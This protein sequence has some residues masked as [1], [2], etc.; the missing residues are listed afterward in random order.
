MIN[1]D[2]IP[3]KEQQQTSARRTTF[4]HQ[5]LCNLH[6][7]IYTVLKFGSKNHLYMNLSNKNLQFDKVEY[8]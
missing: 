7:Q 6:V 3:R 1:S 2:Q 8:F 5:C 4:T